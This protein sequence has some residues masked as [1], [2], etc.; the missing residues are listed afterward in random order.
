MKDLYALYK[1]EIAENK[2]N[3]I[4]FVLMYNGVKIKTIHNLTPI[5]EANIS[6]YIKEDVL[7][8]D[9]AIFLDARVFND[10]NEINNRK[11]QIENSVFICND[12]IDLHGH[13][14][15]DE[16]IFQDC[17]FV[18]GEGINF[19]NSVFEKGLVLENCKFYVLDIAFN[20]SIIKQEFLFKKNEF[21]GKSLQFLNTE[22]FSKRFIL[23]DS[24]FNCE[25]FNFAF[26]KFHDS[27]INFSKNH[28]ECK[29][30]GFRR[31]DFEHSTIDLK[32]SEFED[33]DI[34][35]NETIMKEGKINMK[36]STFD[37]SKVFFKNADLGSSE[38]TFSSIYYNSGEFNFE[39]T[40][41]GSI[42]FDRSELN[43]YIDLRVLEVDHIDLSNTIIR[44][45][46]DLDAGF[47]EV[48]INSM[49]FTGTR[50]LGRFIM[51]WKK[52]HVHSFIMAQKD[53]SIQE[54]AD[55]FNLLK[56]NFRTNGQ[57]NDEDRAYVSFKRLEL[58]A[59]IARI[60]KYGWFKGTW[61]SVAATLQK[62]VYDGM[63]LYGTDPLRVLISMFVV[64]FGFTL[65]YYALEISQMGDLINSVGVVDGPNDW[66]KAMYHSAITFLTI[67]YGDFYPTGICRGLSIAE[68]W[69]GLFM[70]AYFTVAFVRKILR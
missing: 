13:Q 35:F 14:F 55:Q 1:Y 70:M 22:I 12:G 42:L 39:Q 48:K 26:S 61:T 63:G 59:E 68:G 25:E 58:N 43:G 67:G 4:D 38:L 7:N 45:V 27:K 16:V 2:D 34:N 20:D 60:P 69:A 33:T 50:L 47:Y 65:G 30:L 3:T 40:K 64:Y 9:Q 44:D 17:I 6:N 32:R 31:V 15:N 8:F 57:Y 66:Q 28:Y 51:D 23:S 37:N 21:Y 46:V 18:D 62:I 36:F 11:I 56:E 19:T 52:N 10:F 24:V 29:R 49:L 54:K 41:A 53:T 5:T